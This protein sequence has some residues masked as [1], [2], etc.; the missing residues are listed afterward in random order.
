METTLTILS[1]P[2]KNL[3]SHESIKPVPDG[4]EGNNSET[5]YTHETVSCLHRC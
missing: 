2:Y 3:G 4:T 5:Q 1:I